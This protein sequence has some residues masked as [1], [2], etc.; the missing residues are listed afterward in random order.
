M[1]L[2]AGACGDDSAPPDA[3]PA[4]TTA[5][6]TS[7]TA[8]P[9]EADDWC[10]SYA[11]LAEAPDPDPA[12][13]RAAAE[14]APPDLAEALEVVLS[15]DTSVEPAEVL[16]AVGQVES[17]AHDHCGTDHPFCTQ[18]IQ[19][20]GALAG[21]ALSGAEPED[22]EVRAVLEG[23]FEVV[24]RYAPDAVGPELEVVAAASWRELSDEEERAA[25]QAYDEVDAWVAEACDTAG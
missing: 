3:A 7:A 17:W 25:E 21:S 10:D 4:G 20:T 9:G 15:D 5:S 11:E 19:Y 23:M 13:L 1:A 18:W 14:S 16:D 24:L 6:S 8:E 22:D 12:A 2:L